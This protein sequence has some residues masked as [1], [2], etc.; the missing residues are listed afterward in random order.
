MQP[1]GVLGADTVGMSRQLVG[2]LLGGPAL[3]RQVPD[4]GLEELAALAL[5]RAVA[6]QIVVVD[7]RLLPAG[8]VEV[9]SVR[10]PVLAGY[11]VAREQGVEQAVDH[12]ELA[13]LAELQAADRDVA[14]AVAVELHAGAGRAIEGELAMDFGAASDADEP[15]PAAGHRRFAIG[16]V[17]FGAQGFGPADELASVGIAHM[18]EIDRADAGV[19]Q[20]EADAVRCASG[21]R[22]DR[23]LVAS[24]RCGIVGLGRLLRVAGLIWRFRPP[25]TAALPRAPLPA[26]DHEALLLGERQQRRRQAL[27]VAVEGPRPVAHVHRRARA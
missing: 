7:R 18:I 11:A 24:P 4:D 27:Q 2:D 14:R 25:P 16:A 23:V 15:Q 12:R 10:L 8:I 5:R 22:R 20:H 26:P 9:V 13:A 1:V 6:N 21:D 3:G 19:F 17:G